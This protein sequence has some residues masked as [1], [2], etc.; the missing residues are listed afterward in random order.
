MSNSERAKKQRQRR[1]KLNKHQRTIMANQH[2]GDREAVKRPPRSESDKILAERLG[3]I[4][5]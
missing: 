4:K 1:S 5:Q 3:F 2:A